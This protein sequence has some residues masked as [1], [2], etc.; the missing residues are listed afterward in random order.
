MIEMHP[1]PEEALSDGVQSLTP[2]RFQDLT[3]QLELVAKAVGR[4]L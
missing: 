4:S 3:R 1:K 2:A